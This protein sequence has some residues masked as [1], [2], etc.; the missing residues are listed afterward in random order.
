MKFGN[1]ILWLVF[2]SSES[3]LITSQR[4][5]FEVCCS[6]CQSFSLE[7]IGFWYCRCYVGMKKEQ[8]RPCSE[9][10]YPYGQNKELHWPVAY[11]HREGPPG[12]TSFIHHQP[13]LVDR[14]LHSFRSQSS[15]KLGTFEG[16][17]S[18]FQSNLTTVPSTTTTV[19]SSLYVTS[20]PATTTPVLPNFSI[21]ELKPNQNET[22]V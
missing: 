22:K 9:H 16:S 14:F 13:S 19:T 8:W 11:L 3:L 20:S 12:N 7:T 21:V 10:Y 1:K 6:S 17:A 5:T 4:E 15:R 18:Q 2:A